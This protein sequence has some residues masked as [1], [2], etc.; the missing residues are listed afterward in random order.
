MRFSLLSPASI[1]QLF[2][3]RNIFH[4]NK[5]TVAL[6]P[7][8]QHEPYPVSLL[9]LRH[10]SSKSSRSL[11]PHVQTTLEML[12]YKTSQLAHSLWT[13]IVLPVELT[14]NECRYKRMQLQ[15]IRDDRAAVLGRLMGIKETL[16]STLQ[17]SEA[18]SLDAFSV[19][20]RTQLE[21]EEYTGSAPPEEAMLYF[22][23]L[24]NQILPNHVAQHNLFIH[25]HGL[26][27]PSRLTRLWPKLVLL[28][29]LALYASRI[30]YESR[31]SLA[32]TA[33]DAVE[34]MKMFWQ[35]WLLGPLK[36]VV[37][38]VRAGSDV[39][40]IVTKESVK[41]DLEVSLLSVYSLQRWTENT[42]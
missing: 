42:S 25:E 40:V 31:A 24:A 12:T 1:R 7:H 27:R 28:P 26:S 11:L 8:L 15:K 16:I 30:A 20:L 41:A 13:T 5:L 19:H 29:P 38:T 35:D 4:A 32:Q 6:F 3:T 14:R 39:G 23:T 21:F 17:S 22:F 2:P 34:T 9:A 33:R 36:D 10:P 18:S 37:R